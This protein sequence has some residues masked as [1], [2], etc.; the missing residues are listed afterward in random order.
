VR[1]SRA[2]QVGERRVKSGVP[3][4]VTQTT[5]VQGAKS[6]GLGVWLKNPEESNRTKESMAKESGAL[7]L[8]LKWERFVEVFGVMGNSSVLGQANYTT[9]IVGSE[10]LDL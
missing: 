5:G 9:S 7:Y 1:A 2:R 3:R 10:S 6:W 8:L 4:E